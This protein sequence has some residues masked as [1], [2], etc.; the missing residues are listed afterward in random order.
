M[1]IIFH[2]I[3]SHSSH[4]VSSKSSLYLFI[5]IQDEVRSQ[6]TVFVIAGVTGSKLGRE[7]AWKF[8]KDNWKSLHERY[9]GGF[10]LARLVKVRLC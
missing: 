10:L 6:D 9:R 3:M 4:L 8:V 7:M 2:L 1:E 5:F